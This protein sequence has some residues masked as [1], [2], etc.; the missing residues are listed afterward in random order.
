MMDQSVSVCCVCTVYVLYVLYSSTAKFSGNGLSNCREVYNN[1][2]VFK[3][4]NGETFSISS[5]D[6]LFKRQVESIG[7]RF[8]L[9]Y[10]QLWSVAC[11]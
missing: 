1:P 9:P 6:L 11:K 7:E 10:S 8:H 4:E 2:H 5:I 3:C